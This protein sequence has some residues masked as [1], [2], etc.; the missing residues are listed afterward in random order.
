MTDFVLV[1]RISLTSIQLARKDCTIQELATS[2]PQ[3]A[4]T[5]QLQPTKNL[6]QP[7]SSM[8]PASRQLRSA[9]NQQT[10]SLQ[11]IL[12]TLIQK[13]SIR[14][15]SHHQIET[16]DNRHAQTDNNHANYENATT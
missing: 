11:P 14:T 8:Q 13:N 3:Q 10:T 16:T 9:C 15:A 4:A 5:Q 7:A 1:H 6:I 2:N 12:N